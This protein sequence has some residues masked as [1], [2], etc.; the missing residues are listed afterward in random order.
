[1]ELSAIR[2]LPRIICGITCCF[3][4]APG[5]LNAQV[6]GSCPR[7]QGEAFLDANNVR[8]RIVNTGGLFYGGSLPGYEIPR[9][10]NTHSVFAGGIWIAG[11]IDGQ[12]HA[13]I[14]LYSN[15]EFW[16]GPLDDEGDPPSDCSVYDHVYKIRK[17]DVEDYEISG[18]PIGD[19][20]SW[21]TGLGAP[22]LDASGSLLDL[23]NDPFTVRVSRSIDLTAGERPFI[24]GDQLLWWIMND[25]GN[26]HLRSREKP[27]GIEI[28]GSAFGASTSLQ[29]VH[30]TTY[31]RFRIINKNQRTLKNAYVGLFL[32]P[33]IGRVQDDYIG[34]DSLAALGFAYNA[35]NDDEGDYGYGVAP[36]AVGVQFIKTPL[37]TDDGLDNDWDGVIDE[38]GEQHGLSY[39]NDRDLYFG[40]ADPLPL[41]GP[42]FYF[43]LRGLRRQGQSF[44]RGGRGKDPSNPRIRYMYPGDPARGEFWSEVNIDGSGTTNHPIDQRFIMSSGPFDLDPGE[45]TELVFSIVWARGVNNLDSV[46][47]LKKAVIVA[48]NAYDNG[49]EGLPLGPIP[50]TIR[51][52]SPINGATLQPDVLTLTWQETSDAALYELEIIAPDTVFQTRS[53]YGSIQLDGISKYGLVGWRVRPINSYGAGKWSETWWFSTAVRFVHDEDEL[54]P[55]LLKKNYP[56]PVRDR[57]TIQYFIPSETNV[58]IQLYNLQGRMVLNVYSTMMKPGFHE[59]VIDTSR[60]PSGVYFYR[61]HAAER[62]F[63]Q[64]IVVIK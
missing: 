54:R 28:H 24:L 13:A 20:V 42:D 12:L 7:S 59:T 21:P 15:N 55:V 23:S 50:S 25:R 11:Q 52:T 57:T 35:D 63:S 1:M 43:F 58:Q 47:E 30:N 40:P 48:R 36:P 9:F 26:E 10:S 37:A 32:D 17:V 6:V 33:D 18:R 31:Y 51:L 45:E 38:S 34:S 46:T 53:I 39:F 14:T 56:N 22:T 4:I 44:T 16:A 2:F 3:V 64:K 62:Q 19:L 29:E 60:L 8:A 61:L 41:R 49:L 5:V 27:I